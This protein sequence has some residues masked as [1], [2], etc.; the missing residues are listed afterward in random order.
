ML[1]SLP[2]R[3]SQRTKKWIYLRRDVTPTLLLDGVIFDV[4]GVSPKNKHLIPPNVSFRK[5]R[6][7]CFLILIIIL[8]WTFFRFI[9]IFKNW[10]LT[11]VTRLKEKFSGVIL[12]FHIRRKL[13]IHINRLK[14]EKQNQLKLTVIIVVCF[15]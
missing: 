6:Y 14:L 2:K 3:C 1:N 5:K 7:I 10:F 13:V 8:S 9:V 4:I 11:G 15:S 12:L